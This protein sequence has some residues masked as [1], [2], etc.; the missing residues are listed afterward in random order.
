MFGAR[1]LLLLLLFLYLVEQGAGVLRSGD[2]PVNL[3]EVRI[4][5]SYRLVLEKAPKKLKVWLMS[6][7]HPM[8]EEL[9][10]DIVLF[11]KVLLAHLRWLFEERPLSL[12]GGT[13]CWRSCMSSSISSSFGSAWDS[14]KSREAISPVSL[15]VP[16]PPLILNAIV[17][18][19][20]LGG[21]TSSTAN[22]ARDWISMAVGC[23]VF[24]RITAASRMVRPLPQASHVLVIVI[25]GSAEL[26]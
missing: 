22:L 7:H 1:R 14:I 24:R 19:A 18:Y 15:R 4:S 13:V 9:A 25:M 8:L 6:N 23:L 10:S 5:V 12:R 16:V 2:R 21:F 20:F 3:Q 11:N 17:A 26:L